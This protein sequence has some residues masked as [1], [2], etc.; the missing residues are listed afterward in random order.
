VTLTQSVVI[1]NKALGGTQAEGGGISGTEV[2]RID[3]STIAHN[4]AIASNALVSIASIA[5][6]GGLRVPQAAISNSTFSGNTAQALGVAVGGASGDGLSFD[7][8]S[9]VASTVAGNSATS[10]GGVQLG[11]LAEMGST[12]V[13][14]NSAP[15]VGPDRVT[16]PGTATLG[17]N[18]VGNGAGYGG[19]FVHAVAG[20]KVVTGAA[21]IA[22]K[23]AALAANGGPT[24]TRALKPV[25]PAIDGAGAKPCSTTTDQRGVRR[26][27][28]AKCDIGAFERS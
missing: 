22:A 12:I 17:R 13:A 24:Q 8:G 2:A 28:R 4:K 6:G 18:L 20:D 11:N 9:I 7:E 26:P 25:S 14:G 10:G 5:S 19:V 21:P 23:L 1:D 3:R 15:F 16:L 27:Q